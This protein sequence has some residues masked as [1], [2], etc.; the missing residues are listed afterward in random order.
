MGVS[1]IQDEVSAE[2]ENGLLTDLILW[3]PLDESSGTRS[4]AHTNGY[5]YTE[6]GT[7][8]SFSDPTYG[9]VADFDGSTSNFLSN[10][11]TGMWPTGDPIT[12]AAWV[13]SNTISLFGLC[14]TGNELVVRYTAPSN[15]E[16]I[17]N[18]FSTNDRVSGSS[19]STGQWDLWIFEYDGTDI[20]V[21]LNN[22]EKNSVT[23]T[24]SYN[25]NFLNYVGKWA[26]QAFDGYMR[27]FAVWSKSGGLT[28]DQKTAL[29]NSG[30]GLDYGDLD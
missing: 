29:Y 14:A 23:P 17:L 11:T 30:S 9:T 19:I 27:N 15:A 4:D 13:Y 20:K 26:S 22:V 16:I 18:S 21:F 1:F 24:G 25:T 3:L 8:G 10:S 28:S 12:I 5:D 2:S 7:V 6:N